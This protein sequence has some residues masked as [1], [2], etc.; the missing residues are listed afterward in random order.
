MGEYAS[1]VLYLFLTSASLFL[2]FVFSCTFFF[3]FFF[4]ECTMRITYPKSQLSV[5]RVF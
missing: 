1:H 4:C 5:D 2:S 3:L